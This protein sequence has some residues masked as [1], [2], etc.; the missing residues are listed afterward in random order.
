MS[1]TLMHVAATESD[2]L[3]LR[4]ARLFLCAC[5]RR[6]DRAKFPAFREAVELAERYADGRAGPDEMRSM[7]FTYRYRF[8]HPADMLLRSGDDGPLDLVQRGLVWL[9]SCYPSEAAREVRL[10][11]WRDVMGGEGVRFDAAWLAWE[12]GTLRRLAEA[13]DRGRDF[14]QM[15]ILGD[16]LEE[17]G[18]GDPA[19][20]EH[21]RGDGPHAHG[22]WVLERLR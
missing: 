11:L 10:A 1:N 9:E 20:L 19:I 6:M 7:R 8:N 13:I 3:D 17:A 5:V 16:A 22:C 14:T 4:R 12:G 21:C 18:C 2:R 15:P